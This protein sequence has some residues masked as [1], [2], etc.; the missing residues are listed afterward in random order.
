[1]QWVLFSCFVASF[2]VTL[3]LV[4]KWIR[5]ANAMGLVGADMNKPKRPEIPEGGGITVIA[6]TVFGILLYIFLNTFYFSSSFGL[7][8]I[9]AVLTTILLAGFV[10]FIDDILGWK[11]GMRHSTKV[12]STVPIAIPLA[13]VN[14]GYSLMLIP[15]IGLVNFGIIFPMVLIPL[16]IICATNGYNMLAGYNGLESGMGIIM[17]SAL[18]I[19]AWLSGSAWVS[20]IAMCMVFALI[21]FLLFNRP[22]ARIFPGD[23]LTYSV[24]AAIACIA[25]TGNMEKLALLLFIPYFFDAAMFIRFRFLEKKS[26]IEA[27]A[28]AN[29]DG[30]LEL[31]HK[32]IYDFTHLALWFAKKVKK[33]VYEKDVV[34]TV[35]SFE[36][37]LALIGVSLW[38][39]GVV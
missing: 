24:G 15:F 22:P 26:G 13:V 17:L 18:S 29:P 28:K 34:L 5:K 9:F 16:G 8:E 12:L 36:I 3:V 33:K 30:S 27:F 21:A 23:S 2:L 25:I 32:N 14:A 39:F 6:G 38:Y 31:P 7:I 37:A 20:M 1:M 10:G 11:V 35:L 19:V 4:P